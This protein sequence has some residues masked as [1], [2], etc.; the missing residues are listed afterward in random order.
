MRGLFHPDFPKDVRR[1]EAEYAR[2]SDGL[3]SRFRR[4]VDEAV[5]AITSSPNSAGHFLNLGSSVVLNYGEEASGLFHFSSF[6]ASL[7]TG[8]FSAR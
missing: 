4:E 3:A 8:C 2:I 5:D 7:T 6:T 1:F